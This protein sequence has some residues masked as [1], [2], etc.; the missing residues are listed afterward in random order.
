MAQQTGSM[1]IET[2]LATQFTSAAK[3]GLDT[4][5]P[6]LEADIATHN[7]I[8]TSMLG[9]LV[10]VSSDRQRITGASTT[11][12]MIKVDEMGR[13]P[14]QKPAFGSTV[15]FPLDKYQFNLGWTRDWFKNHTPADMALLVLDAQKAHLLKIRTAI[16]QAIFGSANFTF[17]DYLKDNISLTA[18]RFLNADGTAIPDGPTGTVFT[19][20]T[21]THYSAIASLTNAAMLA[22]ANNVLEHGFSGKIKIAINAADEITVRALTSF[23]AYLDPRFQLGTA[24]VPVDRLDITRMDNRAIGILGPAEIW[25]KPWIPATY[26]FAY[27]E[28]AVMKPLVLRVPEGENG[29]GLS[30]ASTMDEYPWYAQFMESY[31][32]VAAWTRTGGAALYFGVSGTWADPTIAG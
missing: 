21:H 15:A 26:A 18:R 20:S 19:P 30:I 9:D 32:G 6:V 1:T 2:L 23:S 12:Q 5:V 4:I 29:P 27:A 11:G 31:F 28:D 14:T 7:G 10:E 17:L 24:S 22:L 8:V 3:F 13:A 16:A 25:V